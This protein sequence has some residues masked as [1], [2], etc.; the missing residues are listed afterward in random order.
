MATRWLYYL[1][2]A[3][4]LPATTAAANDACT[5]SFILTDMISKHYDPIRISPG[6]VCVPEQAGGNGSCPLQSW[7]Y[8]SYGPRLNVTF[9]SDQQKDAL[10]DALPDEGGVIPFVKWQWVIH[11]IV[12]NETWQVPEGRAAYVQFEEAYDCAVT[13][14]SGKSLVLN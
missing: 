5:T 9:S 2:T 8:L 14:L 7:A 6:L 4:F 1:V 12:R 13:M 10:I 11:G 3:A